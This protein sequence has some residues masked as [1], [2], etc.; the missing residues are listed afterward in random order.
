M[1]FNDFNFDSWVYRKPTP[2]GLML[3]FKAICPDIWKRGLILCLLNI[4]KHVCSRKDLFNYLFS[5]FFSKLY[6]D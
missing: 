1:K 2:T 5:Y 6:M 4:A 3:N